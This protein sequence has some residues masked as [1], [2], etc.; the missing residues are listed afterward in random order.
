MKLFQSLIIF[1]AA[2]ALCA[3]TTAPVANRTTAISS[4]HAEDKLTGNWDGVLSEKRTPTEAFGIRLTLNKAGINVFHQNSVTGAWSEA[5]PGLF[6]M[7]QQGGNAVLHATD[8]GRDADGTWVETWVLVLTCRSDDE[9]LVEWVRM[10]N[11]VD[12][13]ATKSGK[14]FSYGATGTLKRVAGG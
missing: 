12:L 7:S 11:N 5:M 9:L 14:T 8:S 10:V 13:P 3:C 6:H 4:P 1:T 2:I